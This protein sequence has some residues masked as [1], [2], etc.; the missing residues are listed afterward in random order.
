MIITPL[1]TIAI[2]TR[3]RSR[4]LCAN[5]TQLRKELSS[6]DPDI[7]EVLVSDNFST[8]DTEDVVKSFINSG[9][10]IQYVRTEQNIGWGKNFYQCFS[11]ARGNYVL[12]LGDDD[13][14]V[15]DAL[16]LLLNRLKNSNYGVLCIRPY[17][18][19][20]N[21][22]EEIPRIGGAEK[23]YSNANQFIKDIGVL[24]TLISSCIL[25]K[26][27]ILNTYH[28]NDQPISKNFQVLHLVLQAA[29]SSKKNLF[30]KKYLIASTRNNS[31]NYVFS[32]LFVNEMWCVI[33]SYEK[34][35][36]HIGS[37]RYLEKKFL[38]SYYP[39]YI[40][41]SRLNEDHNLKIDQINFDNM[42]AKNFF[43][44][45][46]LRPLFW[47]PK[48]FAIIFGGIVVLLGRVIGG[49]LLRGISFF[50]YRLKKIFLSSYLTNV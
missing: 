19:D 22:R 28:E 9:F 48:N 8:D 14:I 16:Q 21:F 30:I 49:D 38:I 47:L 3:N 33:R 43:Y 32:E 6:I 42:Y 39:Y 13:Y 4:Y 1:L 7:V 37:I 34:K 50:F 24:M 45:F 36:L 17:G 41:N 29:L 44:H 2:P 5:L 20:F 25:N 40:L 46:W 31:S 10:C 18:F 27:L 35:G 12:I 26:K 23:E 15:D 11:L